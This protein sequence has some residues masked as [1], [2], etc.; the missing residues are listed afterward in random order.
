MDK[1]NKK[2]TTILEEASEETPL[3][4]S[5][6]RP[7]VARSVSSS[8]LSSSS[9]TTATGSNSGN[10]AQALANPPPSSTA[11]SRWRSH[12]AADVQV[13]HSAAA[14]QAA[15]ASHH[16][17][18]S[19]SLPQGHQFSSLAVAASAAVARAPLDKKDSGGTSKVNKLFSRPKAPPKDPSPSPG[20]TRTNFGSALY[21]LDSRD[22]EGSH[23]HGHKHHL[24]LRPRKDNGLVLSSSSSNS[25]PTNAEGSSIYSFGP[26]SPL[27][28]AFGSNLSKSSSSLD[29]RST[30]SKDERFD[31]RD[32][33]WQAL[34]SKVLPLFAGEGLRTPIEDLNGLVRL[35]LK[36]TSQDDPVNILSDVRDILD[37]GT[38][39]LDGSL[40]KLGDEKLI[41]RLIE[42]WQFYFCTVLPYF[43]AVFL[44]LQQQLYSKMS[45]AKR[46]QLIDIRRLALVAFR[47][48][49]ILP[50]WGQLETVFS[51]V[52][53]SFD[54]TRGIEETA[55]EMLQCVSVLA[56]ILSEDD[57][58]KSMDEL[59]TTLRINWLSRGRAGKD[60]RGFVG[61][62]GRV[63]V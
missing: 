40:Q 1:R 51:T 18:R 3:K 28:A 55:G 50:L 54:S 45:M 59:A 15:L 62:K 22:K 47:D 46:G 17:R 7:E 8:S 32:D 41:P 4:F 39:S 11:A 56:S 34:R 63:K 49:I 2:F 38:D 37:L 13:N 20:V 23:H 33:L 42:L 57:K 53:L 44:P 60:R 58:Q 26:S 43:E 36:K 10:N 14:A 6:G 21:K 30:A 16:R 24:L 48:N 19:A 9:D 5:S 27:N 61:A 25:K 31:T 29:I 35:Y 12:G 52:R